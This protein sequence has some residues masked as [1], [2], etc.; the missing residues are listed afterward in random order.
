MMPVCGNQMP[1]PP[2][3]QMFMPLSAAEISMIRSWVGM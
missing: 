1:R 2:A 3:G